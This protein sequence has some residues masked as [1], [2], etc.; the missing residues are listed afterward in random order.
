MT[1]TVMP[2]FDSDRFGTFTRDVAR[3]GTQIEAARLKA[4]AVLAMTGETVAIASEGAFSPHP[5]LPFSACDREI[6]LIL[7]QTNGIEIVGQA[8]SMDTNYSHM[9]VRSV[10]EA[11]QFAE[12]TGFPHHSLVV[13]PTPDCSDSHMILKGIHTQ[14]DLITAVEA[15]L[16][17]SSTQT[18]HLET[19]MRAMHNPTRMDVIAED[20]SQVI[21]ILCLQETKL[22]TILPP[23]GMRVEHS[24]RVGKKGG[25]LATLVPTCVTILEM[26]HA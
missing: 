25:G 12:K 13:M 5:M 17:T 7:D 14:A 23:A 20:R 26:R 10:K 3:P 2:N 19:D 9:T 6:V 21:P 16:R 4:Q 24:P 15:T 11:I 18:A 1:V 8:L 22:S